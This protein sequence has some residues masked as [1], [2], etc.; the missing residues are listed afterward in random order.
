MA[1]R[2]PEFEPVDELILKESQYLS[3]VTHD[4]RVR[5]KKMMELREKVIFMSPPLPCCINIHV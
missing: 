4:F 5:M 1:A 3:D 2:W